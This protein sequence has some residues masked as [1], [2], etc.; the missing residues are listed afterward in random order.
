G[1]VA[2]TAAI[3]PYRN[4]RDEVRALVTGDGS[5]FVEVFVTAPVEVL[6]QRDVKGLYKKALAGEI[7][8]FTGVSDPYEPP[9][10]PEVVVDS[11]SE[12]VEAGVEKV[13]AKLRELGYVGEGSRAA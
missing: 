7:G 10:A 11:A 2:I 9:L 6:A 4:V 8:H 1:V 3:S 13:L 12:T 5:G